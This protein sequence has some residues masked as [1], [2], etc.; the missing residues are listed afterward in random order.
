M[1]NS[2]QPIGIF[3]SGIGG[4]TVLQELSSCLPE[5]QFIYFGDTARLPYGNKSKQTV[6]RYSLE[7][8]HFLL[9][10]DIK[11]LIIACNTATAYA[12]PALQKNLNIPVLGVIEPAVSHALK[13]S[14]NQQIA[15]LG[16]QG[17]IESGAYQNAIQEKEPRAQLTAIACPLF[18]P[19]VEEG[20]L[21]HPITLS[22]IQEYLKPLTEKEIDTVV[23]GCTH[24]PLLSPWI[25]IMM[26]ERVKLI[27]SGNCC[28]KEAYQL[29]KEQNLLSS[30]RNKANLYFVS[31]A[32]EKFE[33]AAS[34]IF[35]MH[36]QPLLH[37]T[38]S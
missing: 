22:V 11:L 31:D 7:I 36:I 2:S 8:S 37:S 38:S 3:D 19:L 14:K 29:L 30:Q 33:K 4:L 9:S 13:E 28:A 24:Y 20:W 16:T 18:V 21:Q 32:P 23:L 35:G 27:T 10:H 6:L 5:E 17:T 34:A 15:I 25:Q 1:R 12:L 26:G